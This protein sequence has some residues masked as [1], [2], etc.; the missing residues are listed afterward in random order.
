MR[1]LVTG[2]SGFIGT[3][4]TAALRARGDQVVPLG[5]KSVDGGPTWDVDAGHVDEGA[6]AGVDAV[7]HLAGE[8]ILP[9]WTPAKKRRILHSRVAGTRLIAEAAAAAG[10]PV[11]VTSSGIDY[12]GDRGEDQI[13]ESDPKGVG[14]MSDV[15]EAWESAAAPAVDAGLRVVHLRTALVLDG[16]GGS[17][18]LIMLPFRLFVGG[19]IGSGKQWWSWITLDDQVRA[20][21]HLLDR[22]DIRGPVNLASPNPTRNREFMTA[23]GK[24]MRRP[25]WFPT[26]AFLVRGVLGRGPA[27]ALVL[28][29]KRVRPTVLESTGF[30]FRY[31]DIGPA[32]EHAVR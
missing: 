23:L 31:P 4:L 11:L 22:G 19:P 17:L 25:S 30:E 5:R 20:I 6:F 24:A 18:P 26:P 12:Y 15:A 27:D 9:P 10:V 28:E 7:V 8:S 16:S 32:L 13:T 29:S 2:A 1:V 3:A 14:F 21:L